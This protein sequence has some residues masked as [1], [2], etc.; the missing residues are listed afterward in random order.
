MDNSW[1]GWVSLE[2]AAK[3]NKYELNPEVAQTSAN[4][5]RIQQSGMERGNERGNGNGGL[6]S[7]LLFA[8]SK[9]FLLFFFPVPSVLVKLIVHPR[10]SLHLHTWQEPC[11]HSFRPSD[12]AYS[13]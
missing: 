2:G 7:F 1:S 13:S 9:P 11:A 3:R 4:R 10:L 5:C 6:N 12:A 8:F